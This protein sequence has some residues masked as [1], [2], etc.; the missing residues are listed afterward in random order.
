VEGL[1][2]AWT[3]Q[4]RDRGPGIEVRGIHAYEVLEHISILKLGNDDWG[5]GIGNWGLAGYGADK[6]Y[7]VTSSVGLV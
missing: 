1:D 6:D 4:R 5:S 7:K 3:L 2:R